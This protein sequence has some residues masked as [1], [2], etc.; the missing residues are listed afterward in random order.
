M[1]PNTTLG[2]QGLSKRDRTEAVENRHDTT[3]SLDTTSTPFST[4]FHAAIEPSQ[5]ETV[6][7]GLPI[8]SEPAVSQSNHSRITL[9]S[10]ECNND[11]ML[12]TG[13]PFVNPTACLPRISLTSAEPLTD[14][15]K[16]PSAMTLS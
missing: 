4:P 7:I 14:S 8:T 10:G 9:A 6:V 11:D 16:K 1:D 15:V 2:I 12:M 3:H 13:E 5:K